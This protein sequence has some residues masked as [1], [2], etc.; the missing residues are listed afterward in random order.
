LVPG[1]P[2]IDDRDVAPGPREHQCCREPGGAASE[3]RYLEGDFAALGC[4]V[5]PMYCIRSVMIFL[6]LVRRPTIR[7][8]APVPLQFGSQNGSNGLRGV[9]V[10]CLGPKSSL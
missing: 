5:S 8:R 10:L 3:D 1:D 7:P 6:R 2:R 9:S 4:A